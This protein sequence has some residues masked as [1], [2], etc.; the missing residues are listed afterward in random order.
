LG[1]HKIQY[2]WTLFCWDHIK[3]VQICKKK[4]KNPV[5]YGIVILK[6]HCINKNLT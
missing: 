6:F 2:T 1:K 5:K 4:K 3:S